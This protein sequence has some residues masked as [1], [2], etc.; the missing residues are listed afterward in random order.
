MLHWENDNWSSQ[1]KAWISLHAS[2]V[3]S[4]PVDKVVTKQFFSVHWIVVPPGWDRDDRLSAY[5]CCHLKTESRLGKERYALDCLSSSRVNNIEVSENFIL[6]AESPG[7]VPS[8][9]Y[10]RNLLWN[11]SWF[12][13]FLGII[14]A[15]TAQWKINKFYSLVDA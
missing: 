4:D 12:W 11:R 3:Y 9:M 15:Y 13:R 10:N 5:Y 2:T 7:E 8:S 6:Q 14:F 1:I